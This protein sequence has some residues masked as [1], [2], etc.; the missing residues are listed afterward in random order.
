[1]STKDGYALLRLGRIEEAT[2]ALEMGRVRGLIQTFQLQVKPSIHD[3]LLRQRFATAQADL[4]HARQ[5]L[6]ALEA[7]GS[8]EQCRAEERLEAIKVCRRKQ[9]EFSDV[10]RLVSNTSAGWTLLAEEQFT[11]KPILQAARLCGAHHA[12]VYLAATYHGGIAIAAIANDTSTNDGHLYTL[13]LPELN[14]TLVRG[15]IQRTHSTRIIGG[16]AYIQGDEALSLI[17]K[18]WPAETL[19]SCV[20]ALHITCQKAGVQSTLEQAAQTL[21]YDPACAL[22]VNLPFDSALWKEHKANIARQ[23]SH[24]FLNAEFEHLS[25]VLAEHALRPLLAWLQKQGVHSTTLIPCGPLAALPLTAIPLDEHHCFADILPTSVA[26]CARAFYL[27]RAFSSST[28]TH[29]RTGVYT[30]GDPRPTHQELYW[31]EAEAKM[32]WYLARRYDQQAK[33]RV[34]FDVTRRWLVETAL[35]HGK[36]VSL[37]CHSQ[38]IRENFLRSALLLARGERLQLSDLL[39]GSINLRGLRLLILSA[40]Q[41]QVFNLSGAY[42]EVR[43]LACGALQAGAMA[44]LGSLWPVNDHATFLL[45]TRFAQEWFPAMD[46]Q[47]PAE[48]LAQAQH[49]LRNITH[50]ELAE[51]SAHTMCSYQFNTQSVLSTM[52][53]KIHYQAQ[54]HAKAAP[55]SRPYVSPYYWAGFQI[56]GW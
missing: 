28:S 41:T 11:I 33:R 20:D 3:P 49:W 29:T 46:V 47:A 23:L 17:C 10:L 15:L 25:E 6:S 12:L 44:V 32:L 39:N 53:S 8:F 26:T 21:L 2:I 27:A 24:L 22:Y 52:L 35:K 13:D 51:W 43:S 7:Q 1:L 31:G 45:M 54:M 36:V 48:A 56:I 9:Q 50:R 4:S 34:Q 14:Y 38:F 19:Q 55:D 42:N 37:S 5:V 40:C 30:L 16:Y 18:Q